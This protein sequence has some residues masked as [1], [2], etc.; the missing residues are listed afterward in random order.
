MKQ[1]SLITANL[2]Q[3]YFKKTI[4][5]KIMKKMHVQAYQLLLICTDEKNH[6]I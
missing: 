5:L 2:S 3:N 6:E 1:Y 4:N